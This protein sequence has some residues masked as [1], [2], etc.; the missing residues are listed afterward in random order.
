MFKFEN[1][2]IEVT[3]T[4]NPD[5]RESLNARLIDPELNINETRNKIRKLMNLIRLSLNNFFSIR[6]AR[7]SNKNNIANKNMNPGVI[8]KMSKQ[9]N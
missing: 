1:G 4:C 3:T 2:L 5:K 9:I 8:E 7:I 6:Y